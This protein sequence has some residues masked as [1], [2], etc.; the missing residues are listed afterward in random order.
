L[1]YQVLSPE[2][3]FVGV[4]KDEPEVII[5]IIIIFDKKAPE[6]V[7]REEEDGLAMHSG[8]AMPS[9][10]MARAAVPMRRSVKKKM[11]RPMAQAKWAKSAVP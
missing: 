6:P 2:T 1:K 8:A 4:V 9:F 7:R 5:P 3:A 11:F 10:S